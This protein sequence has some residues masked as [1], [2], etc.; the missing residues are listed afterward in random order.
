MIESLKRISQGKLY[1][2]LLIILGVTLEAVAL[3]YQHV[4]GEWPC[5]LCIHIRIWIFCFILIAIIALLLP[6]NKTFSKI[7]HLI[8]SLVMLILIERSWQT[9]AIERGWIIGECGVDDVLPA[10]LPLD[11]WLPTVFEIQTGCGYSPRIIFNI[12]MAETLIILS[13]LLFLVS[14][15]MFILCF[16]K[17]KE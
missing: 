10:W 14:V 17:K 13:I 15:L 4:L 2:V 7:L 11:K 1:W 5:S 9:L 6:L 12:T 8:N 3:Y 16:L